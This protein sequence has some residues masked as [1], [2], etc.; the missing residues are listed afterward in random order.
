MVGG[1]VGEADAIGCDD[2]SIEL[3]VVDLRDGKI[4]REA[5]RGGVEFDA[6][7]GEFCPTGNGGRGG[8]VGLVDIDEHVAFQVVY[9]DEFDVVGEFEAFANDLAMRDGIGGADVGDAVAAG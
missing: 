3:A 7:D 4:H 5:W 2:R 8:G 1:S 6:D 9:V